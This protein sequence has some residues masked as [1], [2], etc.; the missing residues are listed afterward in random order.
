VRLERRSRA[1]GLAPEG[2]DLTPVW[3]RRTPC[4]AASDGR[5]ALGRPGPPCPAGYRRSD[6]AAIRTPL[7]SSVCR[8]S[9]RFLP[10]QVRGWRSEAPALGWSVRHAGQ[11]VRL[12]PS[13]P[14]LVCGPAGEPAPHLRGRRTMP[15]I[16]RGRHVLY[17]YSMNRD[18]LSP[19]PPARLQGTG[20][21]RPG[22]QAD[23]SRRGACSRRAH[24]SSSR[25]V[26]ASMSD[27][28]ARR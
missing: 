25:P 18:S 12:Q 21:C 3:A 24:R 26:H 6:F 1:S 9:P 28:R 2:H 20:Q 15:R 27:Q 17:T 8:G 4:S 16:E 19:G 23:A 5:L 7:S 11:G 13:A 10:R 22:W 14:A